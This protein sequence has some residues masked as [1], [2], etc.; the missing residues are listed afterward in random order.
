MLGVAHILAYTNRYDDLNKALLDKKNPASFFSSIKN[1][2]PLS[3]CVELEF[4]NCIDIS[5]KYMKAQSQ[6]TIGTSKNIRAYVPLESCLA[7]LN[8]I[9]YPYIAKLYQNL[10]IKSEE[11]YLPRFC[12][13]ESNFPSLFLSNHL[14]LIPE[15][16]VPKECF[17]NTGRP[18]VFSH[19]MIHLDIDIGTKSSIEFLKSLIE[20]SDLEIF[21]SNIVK[22]Y[23][24]CK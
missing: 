22:E 12:L 1:E 8:K 7:K 11:T 9:E 2:S 21:R 18:I 24:L 19:S 13:Y 16:I 14:F 15:L 10:F 3:I 20:C 17:S 4:K 5:L 6:G 23:L